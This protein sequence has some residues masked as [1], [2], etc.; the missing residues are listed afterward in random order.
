MASLG[1]ILGGV[2]AGAQA[3]GGLLGQRSQQDAADEAQRAFRQAMQLLQDQ[4]QAVQQDPLTM[5]LQNLISQGIADPTQTQQFRALEALMAQRQ[6]EQGRGLAEQLGRTGTAKSGSAE[7]MA[8][9]IGGQT[10]QALTQAA[11]NMLSQLMTQG[12]Q[13]QRLKFGTTLPLVQQLASLQARKPVF[14]QQDPFASLLSNVGGAALGLAPMALLA[15]TQVGG[16]GGGGG[17]GALLPGQ[18]GPQM[19][20]GGDVFAFNQ[21]FRNNPNFLSQMIRAL[22]QTLPA[23]TAKTGEL[24]VYGQ[25]YP[26][27]P[28]VF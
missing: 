10:N 28:E 5:Q 4:L 27:A 8:A 12:Q 23:A 24:D 16:G 9:G 13:L 22:G 26:P 7:R 19:A 11:A 20:P 15:G 14:Q 3:L 17:S 6:Q 21:Q 2:G 1:A 18:Q 25:P